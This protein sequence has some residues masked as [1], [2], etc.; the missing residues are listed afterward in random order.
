MWQRKWLRSKSLEGQLAYWKEK[1]ANLPTLEL[2][3]S[4]PRPPVPSNQGAR[5]ALDLPAP[6]T[7]ALKELSRREGATLFMTLLAAFQVLLHRYS[8]QDDIA[9]GTPLAG[10]GR[11]E[12]EGLISFFVNTL[13]LRSDLA[14]NPAFTELL[15]RVRET[16]L[17][18]YTHQDLPFE[19]LVE[20][21][22]P[23]RDMSRNPLFQV[24]FA[25]QNAPDAELML[26]GVQASR[27][28][29][30]GHSAKF[31]LTVTARET[32]AGLHIR[33]GYSTDLFDASTVERM[34]QHFKMLLEGIAANPE[35]KVGNLS[36]LTSSER[37]QLLVEWNQTEVDYPRDKCVY[38][39]FE[40][41]VERT[42]EAVAV[43]F[44]DQCLSYA[45]LNAQS[46]QLARYLQ[47]HGVRPG[48][49]VACRMERSSDL[50]VTLLAILKSGGAYV[51]LDTNIP[52][53]RLHSILEDARP[54][55]IITKSKQENASID[56]T[57][58]VE[59][60]QI[61]SLP[62]VICL[63]QHAQS[64]SKESTENLD[65]EATSENLAYLCFTS[66]S[67]GRP[68][69]VRIPHRAIVR[70]VKNTT[71]VS[72][73]A[74]DVFLQFAPVSFDASTFEIWAC[75]LNGGRL[76]VLPGEMLPLAHLGFAIRKYNVSVLWLTA[77]LFHEMVDHELD[78]LTGVRQLLAGGEV[79]STSHVRKALERLGEG[80]LINGYGP[81][82]NTT[83]TC[84]YSIMHLSAEEHSVPIGRPISNTQ[85][86]ILDRDLQPVPIGVRGELF[87]GGDG[88]ALGYLN[89]QKLTAEKFIP[90]PFHPGSLLYR[91][92]DFARYRPDGHIELLGRI[93]NQVKLRGYRI[94]LGEIELVLKLNPA[95]R[96][97]VVVAREDVPGDR[98]LVAYV[99][100]AGATTQAGPLGEFLKERIPAYML[101]AA[102]VFIDAFPLTPNGKL[103]RRALAELDPPTHATNSSLS[104]HSRSTESMQDRLSIIWK[105]LL[106]VQFVGI[107]DDFFELGGHSLLVVRLLAHIEKEFGVRLPLTA[108]FQASTIDKLARRIRR[109]MNPTDTNGKQPL[110]C[111]EYGLGLAQHLGWDQPVYQLHMDSESVA[112]H[113]QIET[114]ATSCVDEIR[115]IQ[116]AGPYFLSGYSAAGIVAYEIAQQLLS[117]GEEV[118]L[119]AIVES[120]PFKVH[121]NR[122]LIRPLMR[123]TRR[124]PWGRPSLWLEFTL[125]KVISV[126]RRTI[127][128]VQGKPLPAWALISQLQAHYKAKPY[129]GRITLF[130]SGEEFD[131][132]KSLRKAWAR[133]AAGELEVII[134]PGDHHTMINEPHVRVLAARIKERLPSSA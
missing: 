14:G 60:A 25:L 76:V 9:V 65:S 128:R 90:N 50:I 16:A 105:S 93:D 19:K 127:D 63:D 122:Y 98:R 4:R 97:A 79:L 86:F 35:Q 57:G 31:D 133:L 39:L 59:G 95:V 8:A 83:F 49:F 89:D 101:P 119:L 123:F 32:A 29:L 45:K 6:V 81:T 77:G 66:G 18:A 51:A 3:T 118:G 11:T 42:P 80:R 22:S 56:L 37:H 110:F 55:V 72:L 124:F 94:E 53:K 44:E 15:A 1:L 23:S 103:D 46:N 113:S 109:S 130:L 114:L 33:W 5:L 64:I 85:C 75:L 70:L 82:E 61:A 28:P 100:P 21:L 36:L 92:G 99:A 129:S 26:R 20:E 91:T 54:V 52:S 73:S 112:E 41:Q 27:L 116:P 47:R 10:R 40:A 131:Y 108:I 87:A 115:K 104:A 107:N 132:S 62:I 120:R 7:Q 78:S 69:G 13:V 68:K 125:G 48:S 111:A 38:Q 30:T 71:Y 106:G 2:P 24:M 102:F 34:A 17:G 74:S 58:L 12:V 88:L 67:S 134:V 84:C 126:S 121:P 43:V 96:D 117:Y